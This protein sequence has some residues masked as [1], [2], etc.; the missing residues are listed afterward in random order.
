MLNP[1]KFADLRGQ[2]TSAIA[3]KNVTGRCPLCGNLKWTLVDGFVYLTLQ[4]DFAGVYIGGSGGLPSVAIVCTN[5]G[6]TH[7][8]NLV[9]LGLGHYFGIVP[10]VP[11]TATK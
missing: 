6:N 1:P 4:Q 9:T 3:S 11:E 5:C 10:P 7:L 2:I 8:L